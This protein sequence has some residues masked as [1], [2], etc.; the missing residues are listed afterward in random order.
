MWSYEP[1]SE[2]TQQLLNYSVHPSLS[3]Y[4]AGENKLPSFFQ[5]IHLVSYIAWTGTSGVYLDKIW[6]EP[7]CS[8]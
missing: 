6:L 5:D 3:L 1:G 8:E 2:S 7:W 4:D